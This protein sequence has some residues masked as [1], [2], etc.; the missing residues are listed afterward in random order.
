MMVA[1]QIRTGQMLGSLLE[2]I[3]V[4]SA[5]DDVEISALALDSRAVE[6]GTLFCA[7]AGSREHGVN[8]AAAAHAAGAVAILW[9]P[10]EGIDGEALSALPTT[11]IAVEGLSQRLG[12]IAARFYGHPSHGMVVTGITGT[13]G[14]SSTAHYV[15]AGLDSDASPCG[16][17]GTL[18]NGRVGSLSEA[19]H[20]TPDAISL[21]RLLAEM[22]DSGIDQVAMEVSSHA[23]EQGRVNGVEFDLALWTNLSRDHLDYHGDMSNYAAAKRRLFAMPGLRAAVI[24]GD[25]ENGCELLTS[26]TELES[27]SYG[28][29]DAARSGDRYVVGSNLQLSGEGMSFDIDSSWGQ[30]RLRTDQLGRFNAS[31]LL[32]ALAALL[33]IG[34]PFGEAI[35][36]IGSVP[37][38]TGRME[39]F[40]VADSPLVVVD[41]AHTPDALEQALAALRDHCDGRLWAV[42]GCGGDRDRG[43][44]LEM[45]AVAEQFADYVVVTDDNPRS[46]D[47]LRI[48]IEILNGMDN[49]DSVYI[50]RDR[51]EAIAFAL[52]HAKP[53]DIVLVAGKG[54]ENYQQIGDE[55]RPFS[56]RNE[57]ERL[58]GERG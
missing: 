1:E 40:S 41:Y 3:V 27:V 6:S 49:P 7:C 44:R 38:V 2:G 53:Q 22:R 16:V 10:A 54:H 56:D 8:H 50:K 25:D 35:S 52:F 36:R 51:G 9:E 31:N 20:T 24:N 14:K 58:L 26:L 23:L 17:I 55:R 13:N 11:V 32:G 21:Q 39:R 37:T 29:S 45:G 48:V 43:K 19:T 42:F 30:V 12:E 47:P 34:L 4:V 46:E 5:A 33:V 57:V 18:G 28:F 15:A